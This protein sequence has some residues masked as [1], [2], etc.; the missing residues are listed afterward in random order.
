ME[1]TI[2]R[3]AQVPTDNDDGDMV[4]EADWNAADDA[5]F[6]QMGDLLGEAVSEV[7]ERW[8]H[9]ALPSRKRER[10]ALGE[11]EGQD[12]CWGCI[13]DWDSKGA[14]MRDEHIAE[15]SAIARSG[16]VKACP[17]SVAREMAR[18]H[19]KLRR[20]INATRGDRAP[21]PE[22]TPASI[23]NHL[24]NHNVDPEIQTAL[25]LYEI[26]EV[27]TKAFDAIVEISDKT[28]EVRINEKQAA[29]VER[30]IKLWYYVSGKDHKKL[31]FFNP[32]SHVD[33][34]VASQSVV[35]T[36]RKA[37]ITMYNPKRHR[38]GV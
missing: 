10:E 1:D 17:Q 26:Q 16:I 7:K 15:M 20:E 37:V 24:R 8:A 19:G 23:L 25:R 32:G 27:L 29:I 18:H 5:E 4:V 28:G 2:D 21:I 3:L 33:T 13:Y 9:D 38:Q 30:Y 14:I 36:S 34:N 22:W 11:P 35:T 12:R 31:A 6:D